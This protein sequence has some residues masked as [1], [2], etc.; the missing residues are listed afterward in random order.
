MNFKGVDSVRSLRIVIITQGVSRIVRPLLSSNHK[1]VGVVESATRDAINNKAPSF[2]Y[3]AARFFYSILNKKA[4]TLER[5]VEKKGIHYRYMLSSND[6]GLEGWVRYLKPDL[7]VVFG[8]SQLL[9]ENIFSIP[10]LGTINMHPA[11]LPDYR[12][13][14]PDFWQYINMEMKPG[15]TIHYIDKGEDT[16]DVINQ[17]R[18]HI[19]LGTK[20]P[21]RLDRLIGDIGVKNLLKTIDELASGTAKS[22]KQSEKSPTGRARNIKPEEHKNVIDWNNWE[23][24]HIWHVLRG[25]ELWLNALEQPKG[26]YKGQRWCV[27][28]YKVLGKQIKSVQSIYKLDKNYAVAT[29]DGYIKLTVRFS[30]KNFII[31]LFKK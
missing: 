20:S 5:F 11:M 24:S 7:I 22:V 2:F 23:T 13:P 3:K 26:V 18:V 27:C 30:M 19:P 28:E 12:G 25:T 4:E 6:A 21:E 1:V 17:E 10:V 14:N 31:Y 8:M 29:K 9:K 15:V 16:G